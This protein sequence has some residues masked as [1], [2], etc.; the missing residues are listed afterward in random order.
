M[1][2]RVTERLFEDRLKF[3]T[4]L[5]L[6]SE[7]SIKKNNFMAEWGLSWGRTYNWP[8]FLSGNLFKSN[9]LITCRSFLWLCF[10]SLYATFAIEWNL[11]T[12]VALWHTNLKQNVYFLRS[13]KITI[14][15]DG[16]GTNW[17]HYFG[18]CMSYLPA[19]MTV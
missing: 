4:T 3:K 12:T 8:A 18:P 19:N 6:E 13:S 10:P 17:G 5:K 1:K 11:Y 7:R 16:R 15:L 9:S 2:K 14:L